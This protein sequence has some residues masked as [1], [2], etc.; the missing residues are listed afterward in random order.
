MS[1][2]KS[3]G[4]VETVLPQGGSVPITEQGGSLGVGDALGV[5]VGVGVDVGVGVG[6]APP[7]AARISTRP[8]P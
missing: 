7:T 4:W 8:Q 6:E 3:V 2:M 5:T 1:T